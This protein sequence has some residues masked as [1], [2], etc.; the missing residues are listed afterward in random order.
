MLVLI[1]QVRC[2]PPERVQVNEHS[3]IYATIFHDSRE[4]HKLLASLETLQD[5]NIGLGQVSMESLCIPGSW[6]AQDLVCAFQDW[7]LFPSVLWRFPIKSHWSSKSNLWELFLL[8]LT[9]HTPVG[10]FYHILQLVDHSYGGVWDL[11]M[12]Q[13][14]SPTIFCDFFFVFGHRIFLVGSRLFYGWLF[15]S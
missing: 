15:I 7:C 11:I 12:S 2:L 14:T 4:G 1:T 5:K 6:S 3:D 13:C 10:E 9:T 8:M